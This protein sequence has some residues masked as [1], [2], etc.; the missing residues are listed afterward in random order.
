[1]EPE[2][3]RVFGRAYFLIQA[4]EVVAREPQPDDSSE[5]QNKDHLVDH[6]DH[7]GLHRRTGGCA[8]V[9]AA[10]GLSLLYFTRPCPPTPKLPLRMQERQSSLR[11]GLEGKGR[12]R[13][14][15]SRGGEEE[16]RT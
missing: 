13:G 14:E 1:M 15:G 3:D 10:L 11:K 8:P 9:V 12:Q 2:T 4:L 7:V 5:H 16:E 6:K